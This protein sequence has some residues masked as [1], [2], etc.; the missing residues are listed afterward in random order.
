MYSWQLQASGGPFYDGVEAEGLFSSP[1]VPWI[2][3]WN[4]DLCS[5]PYPTKNASHYGHKQL[6]HSGILDALQFKEVDWEMV[7]QRCTKNPTYF[8]FLHKNR[9]PE[10][11]G[12]M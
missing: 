12:Q 8:N 11:L 6:T 7:H 4:L 3:V 1:T 5:L 2:T 10:S 9:S